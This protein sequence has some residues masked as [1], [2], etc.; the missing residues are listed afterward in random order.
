M[1]NTCATKMYISI[2][3][4]HFP[5][6]FDSYTEVLEVWLMVVL[7]GPLFAQVQKKFLMTY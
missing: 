5:P 4:I 1:E 6:S 7:A 3:G 2:K